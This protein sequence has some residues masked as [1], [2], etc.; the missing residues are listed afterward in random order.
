MSFAALLAAL[1]IGV[2]PQIPHRDGLVH[3]RVDGLGGKAAQVKIA[4]GLA[5]GGRWFDWVPLHGNRAL[6]RAPGF[7]GVY[8]VQ[9]RLG[10][11]VSEAGTLVKIL[12]PGFERQPAFFTPREVVDWW[13]KR[14][15]EGSSVRSA[16]TWH[17]GFFTHRDPR[18][19]LLLRASVELGG[20]GVRTYY[21]S[22]A[23]LRPNG[24]WRLLETTTAP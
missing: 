22:M 1:A 24:P 10:R 14:L 20:Y 8:P 4:G 6:L 12:P 7:L 19:N 3:V 2:S 21:L 11:T 15:P 9:V 18:F 5:S 17:S 13:A 23:R 16:E